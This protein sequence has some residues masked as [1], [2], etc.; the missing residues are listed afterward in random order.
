MRRAELGL[1][2]KQLAERMGTSHS[3]ISRVES[4][5]HR[6]S[7]A[8]LER[9]AQALEVRFVIGFETGPVEAPVRERRRWAEPG[10]SRT[11]LRTPASKDRRS[12]SDVMFDEHFGR[13]DA[14]PPYVPCQ[15][16]IQR[17]RYPDWHEMREYWADDEGALLDA[18]VP[19]TGESDWQRVVDAIRSTDS[20]RRYTEDG[21]PQDMP[22][23]VRE[24]FKR[25]QT[26]A[27]LW[28]VEPVRELRINCHFFHEAEI[29]FDFDPSEIVGQEQLNVVCDFMRTVGLAL[30]LPVEIGIESREPRPPAALCYEPDADEI[31]SLWQP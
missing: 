6:A 9:L 30:R 3:A 22:P 16:M 2:Q 26:A 18:Y 8:T 29:E 31:Q 7:V 12:R 13:Q 24:I 1:T 5:Q 20:S 4:G 25:A 17:V 23:D 11:V 27:C 19:A 28:Q 21:R 14:H 15:G 10:I